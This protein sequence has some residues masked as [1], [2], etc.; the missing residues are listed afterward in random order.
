MPNNWKKYKLSE[1]FDII[2]GGT[3][4]TKVEAYWNGDIPWLSVVDFNND[5]RTVTS[6]EK[7]ITE[8]GLKNSSTKL[9]KKGQLIISARGTVGQLAQLGRDM[10]FN[11]SCYG[12][13]GKDSILINDYGYYLLKHSVSNIQSNAHGSVFDTITRNTFENIE[14][15]IP[16]IKEQQSI[17]SILSALD[18]K[19]ELNHQMNK[20]LEDMAMALYKHYF[21][22]F[23]PFQNGEFIDS[24]LGPI[25]K[26]WEVKKLGEYVNHQKGFAFKSKWYQPHGKLVVRVSDTTDNSI[27]IN[28][29]NRIAFEKS[30]DYHKYELKTN[31]VII[32][33]VG[34]WPPNYSSVVGKVVRVPINAK[35]AL[36]NQNA[37]RL[38]M[39]IEEKI[40]QGLLYYTLKNDRFLKYIVHS[41]Q[42]SANQASIKLTDIFNFQ[43]PFCSIDVLQEFS[44]KIELFIDR[45]NWNSIETQSLTQ[46]RDT[47]LPKLIS[48]EVRVKDIEKSVAAVL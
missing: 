9:L 44:N 20:T 32:A 43:I 3:P 35:G 21:V 7:T 36:L 39:Q 41:A 48:G 30:K 29:C 42:G 33:T 19:I 5:Q 23:G 10:T 6:T 14:V 15:S 12:L 25:P 24:D 45:Q 18:D 27:D 17:A 2:G 8:L 22:D 4:K 38:T 26:G 34:S 31:D 11:Q 13:I 37:V 47:L 40:F 28:S 1:A 46:L 16:E